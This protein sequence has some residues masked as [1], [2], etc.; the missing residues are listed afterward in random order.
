[1]GVVGVGGDA[2][3]PGPQ[4]AGQ[5]EAPEEVVRQ[6]VH[7][8]AQLLL[9]A[10]HD[11]RGVG[12]DG[13]GMVGHQQ[14]APGGG[15]ALQAVPLGPEPVGVDGVEG[16]ADELAHALAAA[17]PVDVGQPG[18]IEVADAG[19]RR[20]GDGDQLPAGPA[21]GVDIGQIDDRGL[22]RVALHSGTI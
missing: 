17:P 1:M 19:V 20:T 3:A 9:D 8:P 13:P 14:G 16:G 4:R 2:T 12:R 18:G 10:V 6:A 11:H 21:G 22:R 5:R 7:R 15:D